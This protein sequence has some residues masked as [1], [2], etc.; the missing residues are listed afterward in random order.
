M[1]HKN[2]KIKDTTLFVYRTNV[3]SKQPTETDPPTEPTTMTITF[4]KTGM[5]QAGHLN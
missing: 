4:T 1:K 3:N 5:F 2:L